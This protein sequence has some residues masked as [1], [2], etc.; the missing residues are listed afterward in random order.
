VNA[1]PQ[2]KQL[3]EEGAGLWARTLEPTKQLKEESYL[4]FVLIDSRRL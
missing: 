3:K 4:I 2:L 1:A